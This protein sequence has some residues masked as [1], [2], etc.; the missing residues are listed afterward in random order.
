VI[1]ETDSGGELALAG[2]VE[3]ERERDPGFAGFAADL[4]GAG[5]S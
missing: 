4:G 1:E 3:V 2:A 5:G